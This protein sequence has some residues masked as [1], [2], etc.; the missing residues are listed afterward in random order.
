[1]KCAAALNSFGSEMEGTHDIGSDLKLFPRGIAALQYQNFKNGSS[2]KCLG[3][4]TSSDA[5]AE[6]YN[7]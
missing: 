5:I 3:N 4:S 7:R 2:A 1:M 6:D